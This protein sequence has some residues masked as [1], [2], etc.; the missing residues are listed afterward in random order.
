MAHHIPKPILLTEEDFRALNSTSL[1]NYRSALLLQVMAQI[2]KNMDAEYCLIFLYEADKQAFYTVIPHADGGK[3]IWLNL[4]QNPV[5]QVMRDGK[6]LNLTNIPLP[7][8]IQEVANHHAS[9]DSTQESAQTPTS[10]DTPD[11]YYSL[12]QPLHTL[13]QQRL[14]V[15]Q[16]FRK[17]PFTTVD[18]KHLSALSIQAVLAIDN[19]AGYQKLRTIVHELRNERH[20]PSNP[21][22][23]DESPSLQEKIA[24]IKRRRELITTLAVGVGISLI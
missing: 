18:E 24:K 8:A 1:L 20:H 21:A 3:E 2:A 7:F 14:G 13:A 5:E 11:C 10:P 15:V 12:C 23:D 6:T 22:P 17:T 9:P 16:I 19:M 4:E